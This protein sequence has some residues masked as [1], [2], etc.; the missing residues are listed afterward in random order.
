MKTDVLDS[1]DLKSVPT[2]PNLLFRCFTSRDQPI[3]ALEDCIPEGEV[4]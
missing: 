4:V 2:V 1:V 3:A